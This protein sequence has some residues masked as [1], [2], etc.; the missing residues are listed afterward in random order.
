MNIN[1]I[2]ELEI[3]AYDHEGIGIAKYNDFPIFVK[4]TLI[5]EKVKCQITYKNTRIA[6]AKLLEVIEI[7]P[8]RET[9]MCKY[10]GVC[11]GCNIF[12]MSY[13]EQ[14][15]FKKQMVIDTLRKIG[16]LECE[17]ADVRPNPNK[18]HYRNKILVPLAKIDDKI[19]SGFFESKSHKLVPQDECLIEPVL[20][21]DIIRF[22]KTKLEEYNISI[23]D[24]TLHVGQARNIMLRCNKDNE[25]M[26]VLVS[27]KNSKLL[28]QLVIETANAFEQIKSAYI[29]VNPNKTNVILN[30]TGY[31]H[32]YGSEVI[33]EDIN[34]LKFEVHPN[35]FL[36]V[37]HD[38]TEDLYNKALEYV[39][40]NKEQVII[41]AYCGIGSITLNLALKAKEVYGIEVVKQAVDNANINKK[42]NNLNNAFFICGKCEDEISKLTKLKN[43]DTIVFDPPRKGC[44]Q[45][46]LDT[47]I[48]MN[49]KNI[50]YISCQVSTL[51]RDLKYL[52]E[53]GYNVGTVYPFDMFSHTSHVECVCLLS[54]KNF[55]K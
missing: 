11:G 36:Q 19:E 52:S 29:N 47:V 16:G 31:I 38:Q 32:V 43:V 22:V 14:L 1:D 10:A 42:L 40:D 23:Y 46:F 34:G 45:R 48:S 4:G 18:L 8:N 3:I 26:L 50:V 37:N 53:H 33:I 55:L 54:L 24:E 9:N 49:I 13:P 35:S 20:A 17:V 21:K 12:H 39:K 27:T 2:L 5:G 41:D 30:P 25:F 51:A 6:E 15:K 7:S 44:D 28:K